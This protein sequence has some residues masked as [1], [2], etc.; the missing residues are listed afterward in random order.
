MH[1][2][3]GAQQQP[4]GGVHSQR[5]ALLQ[6]SRIACLLQGHVADTW[7]QRLAGVTWQQHAQSGR[8]QIGKT[9]RLHAE[10]RQQAGG[11][12]GNPL[13]GARAPP[14]P[15][16]HH[17]DPSASN[18]CC[19]CW[20]PGIS[21]HMFL[22]SLVACNHTR[23]QHSFPTRGLLS[24]RAVAAPRWRASTTACLDG[25][26]CSLRGLVPRILRKLA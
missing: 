18:S 11:C 7:Q 26:G 5:Q 24:W 21:L 9:R 15:C 22:H 12:A 2:V 8:G 1:S 3:P 17:P 14:L 13:P 19:V 6:D 16:P 25:F 20:L 4:L 10:S 23:R